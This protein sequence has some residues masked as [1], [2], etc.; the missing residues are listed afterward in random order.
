MQQ[1]DSSLPDLWNLS[2]QAGPLG[3]RLVLSVLQQ[4]HLPQARTGEAGAFSGDQNINQM[5]TRWRRKTSMTVL[6]DEM[7]LSL[8]EKILHG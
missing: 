2:G 8:G 3:M 4:P 1:E 5:G 6:G 7:W